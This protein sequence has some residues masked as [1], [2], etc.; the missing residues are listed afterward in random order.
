MPIERRTILKA[1]SL[2]LSFPEPELTAAAAEVRTALA[3]AAEPRVCAF[4]EQLAVRPLLELQEHYTAVFDLNPATSLNLT[5]HLMGDREERGSAL[6]GLAGLYRQAG[7]EPV[8]GE[9]P[10][11]LPL[12][13][14]FLAES[15]GAEGDPLLCRCLAGLPAVAGALRRSASPYAGLVD[16]LCELFPAEAGST[17]GGEHQRPAP[18]PPGIPQQGV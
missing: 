2:C 15:P 3:P 18:A 9:L 14:E 8:A 12:V 16:V 13:L 6:A 4:L 11:Y 1:L 17:A 5:Y 7:Y 10:D